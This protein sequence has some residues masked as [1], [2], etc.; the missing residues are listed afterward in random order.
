MTPPSESCTRHEK[1]IEGLDQRVR[2]LELWQAKIGGIVL[3]TSLV[4]SMAGPALMRLFLGI[5]P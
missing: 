4:G 3:A 2:V 1:A 5:R